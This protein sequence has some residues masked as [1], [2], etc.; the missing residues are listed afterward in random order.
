MTTAS[1]SGSGA[2]QAARPEASAAGAAPN[3]RPAGA[4]HRRTWLRKPLFLA[5]TSVVDRHRKALEARPGVLREKLRK[6]AARVVV[7]FLVS[8]CVG[9]A[10]IG[11]EIGAPGRAWVSI[12]P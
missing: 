11:L 10:L 1:I 5:R 4:A 6:A 7:V 3:R 8:A 12:R 9:A 2:P